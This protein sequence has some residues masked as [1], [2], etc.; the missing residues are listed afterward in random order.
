[1]ILQIIAL[2]ATTSLGS[3]AQRIGLCLVSATKEIMQGQSW[4]LFAILISG[5]WVWVYS[6]LAI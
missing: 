4:F 1:M 6:G 2:L 5:L 3:I